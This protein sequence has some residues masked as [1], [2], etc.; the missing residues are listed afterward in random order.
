M[1]FET[2]I[3]DLELNGFTILRQVL[4]CDRIQE[5]AGLCQEFLREQ[6]SA[7]LSVRGEVYGARDLLR[8]CPSLAATLMT[9]TIERFVGEV[10]RH[11][12]GIVRGLYFDK[13]PGRSWSLPWH[14]DLT[15]AV[16]QHIE[17]VPGFHSPTTKAG[18]AHLVA[19]PWLLERMLTLRFH[20]DPMTNEN[21][22]LLVEPGSHRLDREASNALVG[23]S[24]PTGTIETIHCDAGDVFVMRPLLSHCSIESDPSTRLRRRIVHFELS[25]VEQL[26][27]ELG[28]HHFVRIPRIDEAS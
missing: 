17:N 18:I 22:P 21:G 5:V 14:R 10:L 7:T 25:D 16:G 26:P 13:P 24:S 3:A 4:H 8:Q 27:G 23:I 12:W 15:I 28:W 11:S 2:E 6:D 19:P 1:E 20:L 9:P